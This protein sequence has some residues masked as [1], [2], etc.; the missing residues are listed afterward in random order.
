MAGNPNGRIQ[1]VPGMNLPAP[2]CCSCCGGVGKDCVIWGKFVQ[3]EG[4]VMLCLDCVGEAATWCPETIDQEKLNALQTVALMDK[5][6]EEFRDG[7]NTA[8]KRFRNH[9]R[10]VDISLSTESEFVQDEPNVEPTPVKE[11]G[12]FFKQA[13]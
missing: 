4:A 11:S 3:F 12:R 2:G 10:Y 8:A 13:G 6:L 9:L 1:L 7:F 5:S